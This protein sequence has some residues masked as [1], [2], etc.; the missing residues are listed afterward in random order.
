MHGRIKRIFELMSFL[1]FEPCTP[2][3][4]HGNHI[5]Q[6]NLFNHFE[7][8]KVFDSL[9]NR[10]WTIQVCVRERNRWGE[11][12]QDEY[13]RIPCSECCTHISQTHT[14]CKHVC[15]CV[16]VAF[17]NLVFSQNTSMTE[18]GTFD[19]WLQ[20]TMAKIVDKQQKWT[21]II[22]NIIIT[23]TVW[24]NLDA[25]IWILNKTFP[26]ICKSKWAAVVLCDA[27]IVWHASHAFAASKA[28]C[29]PNGIRRFSKKWSNHGA[30][31]PV[32]WMPSNGNN[33]RNKTD[34]KEIRSDYTD[35][36]VSAFK[37][38][39]RSK[40]QYICG[41]LK[42][43]EKKKVKGILLRNKKHVFILVSLERMRK[44]CRSSE[45]LINSDV[46]LCVS[47]AK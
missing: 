12:G 16:Y 27:Q 1:C 31:V 4:L 7:K 44:H 21:N 36:K 47:P 42:K 13:A 34:C 15:V 23:N 43:K 20:K 22:I 8:W 38:S 10:K 39:S 2:V 33:L 37:W 3:F 17:V 5:K 45:S 19:K 32:W 28:R 25:S 29:D 35:S 40:F 6:P 41:T 30:L 14:W 46:F 18:Y 24:H 9:E 11:G 26:K